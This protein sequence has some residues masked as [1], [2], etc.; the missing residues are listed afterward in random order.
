MATA[1][2]DER[3]L[4]EATGTAYEKWTVQCGEY[5]P[6]RGNDMGKMQR[7]KGANYERQ[8]ARRF[9]ALFPNAERNLTETRTGQG[10][11]LTDTGNLQVQC[12]RHKKYVSISTY[13]EIPKVDGKINV[14]VTKADRLPDMVVLSL[15]DFMAIIE[16]VGVVYTT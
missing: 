16:D 13:D 12:K 8:I 10:I 3:W 1:K 14:L 9:K 2:L 4:D 15:D 5:K 6:R 7:N 11:D